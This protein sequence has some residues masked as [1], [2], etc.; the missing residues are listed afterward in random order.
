MREHFINNHVKFEGLRDD[1]VS[2]ML[3]A[4]KQQK[5]EAEQMNEMWADERINRPM[6]HQHHTLSLSESRFND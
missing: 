3:S 5:I 6:E 2:L 1:V 4:E